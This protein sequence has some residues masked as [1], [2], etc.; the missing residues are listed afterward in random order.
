VGL[1]YDNLD[2]RTRQLMRDEMNLDVAENKLF[3]SPY[4][5]GQGVRDYPNLLL[6]AIE[7][8]DDDSLAEALSQQRRLLR[9]YARRT[10]KHGYIIV[11]VPE[12]GAEI[13]AEGEF[14]RYYIRALARRAIE[15]GVAELVVI[16]AKP[17]TQP[18]PQ[19][20]ALVETSV[21]P[22]DLLADLRAHPG[23]H[24]Q[25]GIPAGPGSGLSVRL[26]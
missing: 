22:R 10:P 11:S 9:S 26:P 15:D 19:A 13:L 1:C 24:T 4:L 6:Q 23:E 5:S 7:S 17:V 2:E 14:N 8:G 20:E 21:D 25:L 12:N 3:I 18:R 16:R